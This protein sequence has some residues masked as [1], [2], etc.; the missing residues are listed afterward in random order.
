MVDNRYRWLTR[1]PG[2]T[3]I[4][5]SSIYPRSRPNFDRG[6]F[7]TEEVLTIFTLIKMYTYRGS[8]NRGQIMDRSKL[9]YWF[10][11]AVDR[12]PTLWVIEKDNFN[13]LTDW[14]TEDATFLGSP[15]VTHINSFHYIETF[16]F[17]TSHSITHNLE[18]SE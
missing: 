6:W 17:N 3:A 13:R 11:T 4:N 12:G 5:I 16:L 7:Q 9:W 1:V 10:L 14:S 15:F 2:P 8:I 18:K